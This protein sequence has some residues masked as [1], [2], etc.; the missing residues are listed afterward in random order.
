METNGSR[1]HGGVPHRD[2]AEVPTCRTHC[3]V[4]FLLYCA[5]RIVRSSQ[6]AS[7]PVHIFNCHIRLLT[8]RHVPMQRIHR[9]RHVRASGLLS[10]PPPP[11]S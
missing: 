10:T 1:R 7:Q 4:T 9:G 6:W 3:A 2:E 5:G 8:A 11:A